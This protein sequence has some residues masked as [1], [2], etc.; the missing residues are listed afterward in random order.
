MKDEKHAKYIDVLQDKLQGEIPEILEQEESNRMFREFEE[1]LQSAGMKLDDYLEKLGKK[2]ADLEKDWKPQALKRVKSALALRAI[3]KDEEIKLETSEIE[4]EM[5]KTIQY[6]KN[7][8]DFEKNV[9]MKRLY[10]YTQGVLENDKVFEL[11]GKIE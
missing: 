1:Q 6:Y 5:N 11:L 10:Q 2:R 9:D 7:V 8:K 3:V 4:A